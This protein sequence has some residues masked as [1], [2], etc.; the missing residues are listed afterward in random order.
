MRFWGLIL[1]LA[2]LCVARSAA[3]SDATAEALFRAGREA[4][5]RGDYAQACSQFEESQRLEP[6]GGTAFNLAACF[7]KLGRVASAWKTYRE[8]AERLPAGDARVRMSEEQARALESRLPKLTLRTGPSSGAV[9]VELN[10]VALG[11]ATLGLALP[12]DPGEQRI[13]VRASGREAR[14]LTVILA[15]GESKEVVLSPGAPVAPAGAESA[16]A[17]TAPA[18]PPP[19]DKGSGQRTLGWVVGGV[20]LA[21]LTV[22]LVT[23]MMVLDKKSTVDDECTDDVCSSKGDEAASSGRTLSTVS[24]AAFVVG[25]VGLGVGTYLL[26]SAPNGTATARVGVRTRSA[27]PELVLEGTFQ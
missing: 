23:G 7:E 25:A 27:M 15:E 18:S 19:A 14:E 12:V 5:E 16:S 24:T 6:A 3:A 8:A 26:L 21:G 10:G 2:C 4:M 9:E 17:K 22:S 1:T 11:A 20:G 13:V